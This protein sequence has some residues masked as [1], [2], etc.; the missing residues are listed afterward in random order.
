MEEVYHIDKEF[1][2]ITYTDNVISEREFVNCVFQNCTLAKLTFEDCYFENCRFEDSDLTM[3]NV[4]GSSFRDV[5]FEGCK[6]LGILWD[7]AATPVMVNFEEC[8]LSFSNFWGLSLKKIKIEKCIVKEVNFS[9]TNLSEASF[10]N[11]DLESSI[12]V[13]TNL[14]K[15]NFE[16][17][18]NYFFNVNTNKVKGALFSMPEVVSLLTGLGIKIKL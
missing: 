7:E 16:G 14:S 15:A 3:V 13:N 10:K 6:M 8:V 1:K 4:K 11:S 2:N 9:E 17:A 5:T 12:F 18:F